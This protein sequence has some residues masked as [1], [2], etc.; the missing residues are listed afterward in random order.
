MK[1]ELLIEKCLTQQENPN[2]WQG[3]Q[4]HPWFLAAT[5]E[6]LSLMFPDVLLC[7]YGTL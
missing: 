6:K 4:E 1:Y 7:W 3:H 2:V 5:C